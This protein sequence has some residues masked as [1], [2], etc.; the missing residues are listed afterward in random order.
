[1]NWQKRTKQWERE[2]VKTRRYL[3]LRR[4]R[5]K[6]FQISP[7]NKVLDLGCGDGLNI[8]LLNQMGISKVFG[9]DISSY[10]LKIAQKNNPQTKFYLASA[11]KLPFKNGYFD[12][13][14]IDSTFY[15]FFDDPKSLIEIRRVLKKGGKL[16]FI[17]AHKS[18]LRKLI[19]KF[20]LSSFANYL[21]FFK[22]RQF[23][24][25]AEK[26]SLARWLEKEETFLKSLWKYGFKKIFLKRDLLSI[27]GSYQRT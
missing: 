11:K 9:V 23:A 4:R 25:M 3:W 17:E 18:F 26:I 10:L 20:T 27:I 21:P 1:M 15:H 14:L 6:M 19:D 13:I 7:N 16:N 5:L 24:Y 12:V 8:K 2:C 22:G